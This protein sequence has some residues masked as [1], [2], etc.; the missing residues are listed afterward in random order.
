MWSYVDSQSWD[1]GVDKCSNQTLTSIQKSALEGDGKEK[2]GYKYTK[3]DPIPKPNSNV[4]TNSSV[5]LSITLTCSIEHN[6]NVQ[7]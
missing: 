1:Q 7:C 4:I 6:P 3:A 2:I 5:V